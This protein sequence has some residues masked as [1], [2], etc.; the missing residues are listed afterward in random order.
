MNSKEMAV[1]ELKNGRLAM[2]SRD[3]WCRGGDVA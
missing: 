1:K 3:E 2:V